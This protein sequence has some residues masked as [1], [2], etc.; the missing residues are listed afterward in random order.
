MHVST[1]LWLHVRTRL[2]A[3]S[4]AAPPARNRAHARAYASACAHVR[5]RA[6]A[7][8][9]AHAVAPTVLAQVSIAEVIGSSLSLFSYDAPAV[10]FVN[11]YNAPPSG[12]AS[13]TLNGVNFGLG[14]ADSRSMRV[15]VTPCATYSWQSD[16]SVQCAST[17]GY[18]NTVETQITVNGLIGTITGTF[19]YDSPV[20]SN[21]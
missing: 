9:R 4:N 16:T 15:G 12:M 3:R 17:V 21:I 20:V 6:R 8:I 13:M 10:T 19:S 18:G 7:V 1:H 14:A 2:D 5:A 11:R